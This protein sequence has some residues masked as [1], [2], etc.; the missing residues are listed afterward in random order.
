MKQ[1][2]VF[3]ILFLFVLQL[4]AQVIKIDINPTLQPKGSL[5]LSDLVEQIE[6][7]PLETKNNCI[8]GNIV[9]FDVSENYIVVYD[10]S[11]EVFL[12]RR[13]GRFVAKIGSRGQGPG[14]YLQPNGVFIDELKNCVYVQDYRKLLMYDFAGKHLNTF[15]YNDRISWIFFHHNNQ[16]ISG[17]ISVLSNEDYYVYGIWDSTM[18]LVKQEVK[19]ALVEI[20]ENRSSHVGIPISRYIYQGYL[21]LKESV[22]ND[23]IYLLNKNNEFIPKYIINCGRYSMTQEMKGDADNFFRNMARVIGGMCFFE[24]SNFLL[25]S[26]QYNKK[27]I[28]CYYDKKANKLLYFNSDEGI[29]DDFT[30]GIDFVFVSFFTYAR[31]KNNELYSFHNAYNLLNKYDKQNK[32]TPKGPAESVQKVQSLLENLDPEDNP[33]LI[34]ATLKE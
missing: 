30:G 24:T 26:Y 16:F 23:T 22:L 28:P 31:Q 19:G 27:W 2:T 3:V 20:K 15:S 7:I 11:S 17:T 18:N 13:T 25:A 10:Q 14:E 32:L 1:L 33:V 9:Y 5:M 29:L 12:F 4:H 8:V 34:I 21:H 6:Y